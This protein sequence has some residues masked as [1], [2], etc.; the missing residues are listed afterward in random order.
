MTVDAFRS[1]GCHFIINTI[2]KHSG[3]SC[4]R[5]W[6]PYYVSASIRTARAR[7]KWWLPAFVG[8]LAVLVLILL[9][10]VEHREFGSDWLKRESGKFSG[11]WH[12]AAAARD[13]AAVARMPPGR[14]RSVRLKQCLYLLDTGI[15]L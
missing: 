14:R 9:T 4:A 5:C 3:V 11:A 15:L 12:D 8:L 1:V 10:E 6:P 7:T 2:P 13:G